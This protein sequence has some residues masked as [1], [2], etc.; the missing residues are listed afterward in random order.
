[1]ESILNDRLVRAN[2]SNFVKSQSRSCS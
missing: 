2:L 1:M